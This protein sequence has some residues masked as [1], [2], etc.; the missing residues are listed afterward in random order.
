[1]IRRPPRSTLFPYTTLFRSAGHA[2][3]EDGNVVRRLGA[4]LAPVDATAD[5]ALHEIV[6]SA[7]AGDD[8][9]GAKGIA[10]PRSEEHTSE[11]QS[12]CNLVCRLLLEK[13]KIS[14]V[15]RSP[16][17]ARPRSPAATPTLSPASPHCPGHRLP[18]PSRAA[19]SASCPPVTSQRAAP[20]PV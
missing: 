20:V 14:P 12:P 6:V 5:K 4:R 13:K 3:L 9:V 18:V 7:E 2:L 1:M 15:T 17:P 11:L 16:T 19:P 8:A 10:V